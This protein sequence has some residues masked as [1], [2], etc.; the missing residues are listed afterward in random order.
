MYVEFSDVTSPPSVTAALTDGRP[1]RTCSETDEIAQLLFTMRGEASPPPSA[2]STALIPLMK[3]P[4][5]KHSPTS[6]SKSAPSL[7]AA[8]SP[9]EDD[10]DDTIPNEMLE[11]LA[12]GPIATL[13]HKQNSTIPGQ[14][15]D[16]TT[17]A[18]IDVPLAVEWWARLQSYLNRDTVRALERKI[19]DTRKQALGVYVRDTLLANGVAVTFHPAENAETTIGS[20]QF[21]HVCGKAGREPLML[22]HLDQTQPLLSVQV[23]PALPCPTVC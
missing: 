2:K 11:A 4:H 13:F 12:A 8:A 14:L 15:R 7:I 10:E 3:P 6:F 5:S 16:G 9:L 1:S 17:R 20:T 18:S 23:C 19:G 21:E 22:M